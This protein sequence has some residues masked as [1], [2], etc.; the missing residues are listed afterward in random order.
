MPRLSLMLFGGF[1]AR[2][3][4]QVITRFE[5]VRVRALL[6]YLV[7]ENSRVHTRDELATLFW[8]DQPDRTA[9]NNLRQALANLR[10]AIGDATAEPSFLFINRDNV[11]WNPNSHYSL[12]VATF[13]DLLVVCQ[14]HVHRHSARCPGCLKRRETAVSLY[15]G[16]FLEP[17]TSHSPL[18]DEWALWRRER[19]RQLA[20][21]T[22]LTLTA[23]YEHRE[24]YDLAYAYAHRQLELDAWR[25]ET[26]QQ[27]MRLLACTGQRTAALA[28][29][30]ACVSLLAQ[31]LGVE[32]TPET[33]TLYQTI[34]DGYLTTVLSSPISLPSFNTPFVGRQAEIDELGEWLGQ[35]ACRLITL[36]GPGGVGKTRL[37]VAAAQEQIAAFPDGVFF[38]PLETLET[39]EHLPT[40]LA[41][42]FHLP[43]TQDPLAQLLI[44]LQPKEMLLI[45]DNYEHL[46]PHVT[47]L[48]RLLSHA[49]QIC[50]LVTSREQLGLQAERVF[51]LI[52]LEYP[53]GQVNRPLTTYSAVQLFLQRA[54]QQ[55]RF[56]SAQN[57]MAALVRICQLT[58]GLPLAIELAAAMVRERSC[59]IIATEMENGR[60]NLA[61]RWPD[62]AER[63]RSLWA[64][65]EHSWRLL[66]PVEQNVFCRMA[67]FCGGFQAETAAQVAEASPL[68]LRM[69]VQKSLLRQGE[70]G[71]FTLHELI[72]QYITQKL[73]ELPE[74]D[75]IYRH[76]FVYFLALAETA[77]PQLNAA[78]QQTWLNQLEREQAN[79][80]VALSWGLINSPKEA[81]RLAGALGL[82]WHLRG[83]P[84]EGG[85]WMMVVLNRNPDPS[86]DRAKAL[87]WAGTLLASQGEAALQLCQESL[88]SF[89]NL[90]DEAGIAQ[91]LAHMGSVA[92][93]LS[94]NALAT[95]LFTESLTRWRELGNKAETARALTNCAQ[96]ARDYLEDYPVAESYLIESLTLS[97]ELN[98]ALEIAYALN[99]L[100]T[101]A[102]LQGNYQQEAALYAQSLQLFQQLG[103]KSSIAWVHCALGE[104]ARYQQNFTLA[105]IHYQTSLS[106]FQELGSQ[107]GMAVV[108][109]L[110]GQLAHH[111]G[112][113]VQANAYY[114]QSFRLSQSTAFPQIVARSLAGLG[115]IAL[116]RKNPSQ[117]ARLLGMAY[118]QLEKLPVFLTPT[119]RA[120]YD[121]YVQIAQQQLGEAFAASWAEG[122]QTQPYL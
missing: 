78:E 62:V 11:Q 25:E 54:L 96:M 122:K 45:L 10:Q 111:Q 27:I 84:Q 105:H 68:I 117:A 90:E 34:R 119:D 93:N 48:V 72:R 56:F 99:G 104:N 1:E 71:R 50:L 20:L 64:M 94:N 30:E 13:A 19:W 97:R 2:L 18:F 31:E 59:A 12:D 66:S 28:Q 112:D 53:N 70:D 85:E 32:P 8:P 46:L 16:N 58:E 44:Y 81:L 36:V 107:R 26:H 102:S 100:A 61:A 73:Q 116:Q 21:E 67:A 22:L 23:Y 9:H 86:H 91:A 57:E 106:L 7:V 47:A 55:D 40:A 121:E 52:G 39:A 38:V 113:L 42:L 87:M 51:D 60:V 83:Y 92:H 43:P 5:S 109:Y 89:Q 76:H 98:N 24:A 115:G 79:F 29:Y 15:R 118:S 77:E 108:I 3:D 35:P 114:Q 4:G 110:S 33:R 17:F 6:A 74:V 75:S 120:E 101:L 14:K 95:Q 65:M 103:V 63:H 41:A 49:P 80:R 88:L 69:L 37:A 82:F